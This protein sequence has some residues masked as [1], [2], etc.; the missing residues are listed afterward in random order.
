MRILLDEC[1]PKRLKRS[2]SSHEV[3]TVPE[4]GWAGLKNGVLLARANEQFDVFITTDKNI[5]HQQNLGSYRLRFVL[6]LAASNDIVDLQ[7]LIPKVLDEL[8]SAA[9]GKL[10][11]IAG[12]FE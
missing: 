7:P 9:P 1:V 12:R 8:S 4:V 11:K 2:F 3:L 10:L 5:E 6:L